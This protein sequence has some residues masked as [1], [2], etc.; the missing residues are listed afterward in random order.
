MSVDTSPVMPGT[1]NA[2]LADMVTILRGQR[3]RRLDVV[4]PATAIHTYDGN[5][6]IQERDIHN[7]PRTTYTRGLDLSGNVE[8]ASLARAGVAPAYNSKATS[9]CSGRCGFP[10]IT[11][12]APPIPRMRVL[13]S[14]HA[15]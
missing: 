1:R 12:S 4:A 2:T 7:L 11:S 14:G 15:L 8:G 9:L 10:P 13:R 5:L 3:A 6:V